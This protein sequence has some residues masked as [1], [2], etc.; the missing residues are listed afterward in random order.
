MCSVGV[1]SFLLTLL[2]DYFRSRKFR[3]LFDVQLLKSFTQD[4][5]QC[6][7]LGH[8]VRPSLSSYF[9]SGLV[10]MSLNKSNTHLFT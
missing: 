8:F 6:W 3:L 9:H 2:V 4:F 1:M 5:Q 7:L 10:I